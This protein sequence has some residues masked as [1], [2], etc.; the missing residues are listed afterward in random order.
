MRRLPHGKG[1]RMPSAKKKTLSIAFI[2]TLAL[3]SALPFCGAEV[4]Y[5]STKEATGPGREAGVVKNP[6]ETDYIERDVI[7]TEEGQAVNYHNGVAAICRPGGREDFDPIYSCTAFVVRYYH[8]VYGMQVYNMF[9]YRFP[10]DGKGNYF[11]MTGNPKPGDIG[12][13]TNDEGGP[14]WFIVKHVNQD[15][16]I[17]VLEQNWKWVENGVTW[18]TVNRHVYPGYTRE[19]MFFTRPAK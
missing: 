2:L 7:V 9:Q 13:Q 8:D 12:Y 14:H 1:S 4:S 3:S 15:G 10:M 18:H 11:T 6:M 17:V 19:L 5:A 16:S